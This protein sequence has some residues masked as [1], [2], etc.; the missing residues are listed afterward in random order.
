[1][2][3]V[4][5]EFGQRWV[6]GLEGGAEDAEF[7]ETGLLTCAGDVLGLAVEVEAVLGEGAGAGG[8]GVGA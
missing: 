3:V 2:D 7:A 6:G 1:M 4:G 5:A 8:G